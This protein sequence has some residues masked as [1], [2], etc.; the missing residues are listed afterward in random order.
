MS[1]GQ[2]PCVA[3]GW[4]WPVGRSLWISVLGSIGGR[5][6]ERRK[7]SKK[8]VEN[9]ELE[10]YFLGLILYIVLILIN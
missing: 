2:V 9:K 1:H 5:G 4:I 6:R 10:K 7:P 3:L 8:R